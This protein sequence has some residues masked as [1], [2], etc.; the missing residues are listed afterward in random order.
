VGLYNQENLSG[1]RGGWRKDKGGTGRE[2]DK[3]RALKTLNGGII[4]QEE[5]NFL[6]SDVRNTGGKEKSGG[7]GGEKGGNGRYWSGGLPLSEKLKM[8]E[9]VGEEKKESPIHSDF[10]ALEGKF[11]EKRERKND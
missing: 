8:G 11:E 10:M 5:I 3:E 7:I 2:K 4:S 1:G 6:V 9:C